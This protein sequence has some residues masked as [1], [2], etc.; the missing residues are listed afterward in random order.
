MYTSPLRVEGLTK[1][2]K[3]LFFWIYEVT[4]NEAPDAGEGVST[5]LLW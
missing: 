4:I 2:K 5:D 3:V 1:R